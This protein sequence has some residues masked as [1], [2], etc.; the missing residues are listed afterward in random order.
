[1]WGTIIQMLVG[2]MGQEK[3]GVMSAAQLDLLKQNIADIAGIDVPTLEKVV[4]TH[5]PDSEMGNIQRD[6]GLRG[7]QLEQFSA[8]RDLAHN[9]GMN[10]A[11]K[12]GFEEAR[13]EAD[14]S[15][16][17]RRQGILS[18]MQ[19]RG[20]MDSGASLISQLNSAQDAAN[21]DRKSG[22][23]FAARGESRRLEALRDLANGSGKLREQ[24]FGEAS[25]KAKAQD[26]INMWNAGAQERANMYNAG[27]PQQNYENR[28]R[29]SAAMSGARTGAAGYYAGEANRTRNEY[30]NLGQSAGAMANKYSERGNDSSS[31]GSYGSESDNPSWSDEQDNERGG[32]D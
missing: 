23:D 12:E 28:L 21:R 29:K 1:M 31:G 13:G 22:Q 20:Q 3:A 18:G 10:L 14:A 32:D 30:S 5:A 11:D 15:D 8:L 16:Y 4:A 7:N 19:Q 25:Q 2:A 26:A 9:G 24:D 27:L 6:E 17:R